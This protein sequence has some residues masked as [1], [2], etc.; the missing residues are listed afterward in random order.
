MRANAARRSAVHATLA[1]ALLL[2]APQLGLD[3]AP[4]AS[5][6]SSS[7]VNTLPT[8]RQL[9]SAVWTGQYA[10]VFGSPDGIKTIVRYDPK[11]NVITPM[12]ANLTPTN[13]FAT[14]AVWD[15]QVAYIFGGSE[16]PRACDGGPCPRQILRY[17]PAT[18]TIGSMGDLLPTGLGD[19]SAVWDG[20]SAYIFGGVRS[21]G[22]VSNAVLR[23]DPPTTVTPVASLPSA[24][25]GTSAV[26]DGR[27][28]YV[29]G[30]S[31]S[32]TCT[33]I[34]TDD[35]LRFD[36]LDGSVQRVGS[37]GN[38]GAFYTAAVWTGG[39]ALIMGG[40][41]GHCSPSLNNVTSYDPATGTVVQRSPG[42]LANKN[43]M[44]AVWDGEAA[45]I[46]GGYS[47]SPHNAVERYEPTLPVPVIAPI[48]AAECVRGEGTVTLDGSGSSHPDGLPISFLW[49]TAAGTVA[50]PS[51]NVTRATL[52]LGVTTVSLRVTAWSSATKQVDVRVADTIPPVTSATPSGTRGDNGWWV[53]PSV[54]VALSVEEQCGEKSTLSSVDG[55]PTKAGKALAVSGDGIHTVKFF[56][57]DIGGNSEPDPEVNISI[58]TLPPATTAALSGPLGRGG[59]W[60]GDVTVTLTCADATSGCN[61]TFYTLD[62]VSKVY[63]G[64]FVVTGDGHHL[65]AFRSEDV[66]GNTETAL[67]ETIAIDTTP[68]AIHI[69]DPLPGTVYV[70]DMTVPPPACAMV[71]PP[72]LP[73]A[74]SSDAAGPLQLPFT[75]IAGRKTIVEPAH[76][77]PEANVSGVQRVEFWVDGELR[78]VDTQPPYVFYWEAGKEPWKPPELPQVPGL[79]VSSVPRF[80][81]SAPPL[82]HMHLIQAKAVDVAGLP[83]ETRPLLVQL[84]PTSPHGLTPAGVWLLSDGD[85]TRDA[86][87]LCSPHATPSVALQGAEAIGYL[88]PGPSFDDAADHWKLSVS[89]GAGPLTITMAPAPEHDEQLIPN[90]DL[91]VL[92]PDCSVLGESAQPGTAVETVTVDPPAGADYVVTKVFVP[93]KAPGIALPLSGGEGAPGA[94]EASG[95]PTR[96]AASD[97]Y[98]GC[99]PHCY[100]VGVTLTN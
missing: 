25:H 39:G 78:S 58:D 28:A 64:P 29:F 15:G 10:Y 74:T 57:E 22:T 48:P 47:G 19:T 20:R 68:P 23:Y 84:V 12:S 33:C 13:L 17:D 70:N 63:E 85:S 91:Q 37:L 62:S 67:S 18:D 41:T 61:R 5:A 38:P 98:H 2:I 65:L 30:G 44:S 87:D 21:D 51:A 35:I 52:P 80:W 66:A 75:L 36:P 89:P 8:G 69:L 93:E 71:C 53:S 45:Y 16:P 24:R 11:A 3:L 43:A 73:I 46:F 100:K 49:S 14:S 27:Y 26:W 99:Y 34:F 54:D 92:A 94:A 32:K 55:G 86:D 4:P 40:C 1:L 59:W 90:Y 9:T 56:S 97:S 82:P 95:P 96:G 31:L 77:G 76:D 88:S 83:N 6:D 42:L 72:P 50:E 7:I 81:L 60:V 79:H